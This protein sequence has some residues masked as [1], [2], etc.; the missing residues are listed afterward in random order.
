MIK[1]L[2]QKITHNQTCVYKKGGNRDMTDRETT[3]FETKIQKK[4][5]LK[6]THLAGKYRKILR[7]LHPPFGKHTKKFL[8]KSTHF[9]QKI[10]KVS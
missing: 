4:I 5:L 3:H 6:D 7:K 8:Q 10:Q 1:H 9:A 2:S